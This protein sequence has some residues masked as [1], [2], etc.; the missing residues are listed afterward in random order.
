MTTSFPRVRALFEQALEVPVGA[1]ATFVREHSGG[2]AA[3]CAEVEALL[4]CDT[5]GGAAAA[6][7]DRGA[8]PLTASM[9][10]AVAEPGGDIGGFRVVRVLGSGGMGTV[11]EAEQAV[12]QRLVAL[13]VL[14]LG[15]C[16]EQAVRRFRW[17]AEVL[18]KLRHP[19]IAQVF[20]VGVHR[21]GALELPWFAMELVPSARELVDH[22]AQ[23][24][25]DLRQR[26]EL[27]IE[28]C[29]AVHHGHLQGVVHRDLKPQNV[30]V[31]GDGRVK[32]I[33]FGIARSMAGEAADLTQGGA[34]GTPQY[35][36]PEQLQGGDV[37]L[38]SDVYALGVILFELIAGRRPF[39]AD[40]AS[41]YA[42]AEQVIGGEAPR[43]SQFVPVPRDLELVVQMALCRDVDRRYASAAALA[44][45][46]RA[47]LES[48][49]VQAR[50]PSTA[51]QLRL[52]ARRRRGLV[53][54]VTAIVAVVVLSLLVVLAQNRELE[55]RERL[56][57]RVAG[58]ARDF[59][60]ESSVMQTRGTDY[61]VRE[62]LDVA[63]DRLADERF[64]DPAIE[65]EL[66][67]LVGETY[68]GLSLPAVAEGHLQ[69]AR[70]LWTA[71][72]GPVGPR[73]MRAATSLLLTWHDLGRDAEAQALLDELE[74]DYAAVATDDATWWSL[75]HNRAFLLRGQG[76]LRD[77][78][79]I[80]REVVAARERLLGAGDDETI[81]TRH[82]LGT[83]LM[84]LGQPDEARQVLERA[85]ADAE[86]SQQ[87]EASVWQIADNLA[88]AWR[89]GGRLDEAAAMHRRAMAGYEQLL[90]PDHALTIGCGYHL[91]K[92]LFRQGEFDEL[93]TLSR[94]LLQR[95]T[96]AFG[97]DDYRTLDVLQAVAIA[98]QHDGRTDE[99]LQ[100]LAR[101]FA[102]QQRND[103][104][105]HPSTINF[106]L[107]L[108]R[109]QLDAGHGAPA[110]ALAERLC[111]A[112]AADPDRAG[113]LPPG[114]AGACQL[115]RAKAL[116][117]VGRRDEARAA[118]AI[119]RAELAA[120]L[121]PGHDL[122]QQ[123]DA[124]A[125]ELADR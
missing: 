57:R 55:Q 43:L 99:A 102:T 82:N 77:A 58:F 100:L 117:A 31:D 119:A 95:C 61:T 64:E 25:L 106:G 19:G 88:E 113:Q 96:R 107:R 41:P 67:Q 70:T 53:A 69:R 116:V 51:H 4:R 103:G 2:D 1:R 115:C 73:R 28:V 94:E 27:L 59:L 87:P 36:S 71:V 111:D 118:L 13:K 34:A 21:Q 108:C 14:S 20:E 23:Q 39:V 80:Y 35:M 46:L 122:L 90:G 66:R 85:L 104:L 120:Q 12:P 40:T 86:A 125:A 50:A 89:E 32:V 56:A 91:L 52:F 11:Y 84:A 15:L 30:L 75:R 101:A 26:V 92:V 37:D 74:R 44:A 112:L 29:E 38:R 45:D 124:V 79:A 81:V 65:A 16:S 123:V 17:E 110:L 72:E 47:W 54:A 83:L 8:A 68:R 22:A 93:G 97:D 78:E 114:H 121:P 63:A 24:G 62:A 33:D 60:A 7:L 9:A 105:L 5:D 3:L 98:C 42:I 76:R 48:R 109:T 6:L 49:P 18:A 10:S